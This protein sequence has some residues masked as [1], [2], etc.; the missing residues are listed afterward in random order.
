MLK[1]KKQILKILRI[2]ASV[3]QEWSK[4][5]TLTTDAGK[6]VEQQNTHSLLVGMRNGRDSQ[7]KTTWGYFTKLNIL[8]QSNPASHHTPC[9]LPNGA[10]NLNPHK[11]PANI[12][13]IA[14]FSTLSKIGSNQDAFKQVNGFIN[15]SASKPW[16]IIQWE[17]EIR[18]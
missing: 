18:Y 5:R 11:N 2:E 17:K 14:T 6:F 13:F 8:L 7:L 12:R 1:N 9:Y 10:E 16:I 15:H 4:S 3:R